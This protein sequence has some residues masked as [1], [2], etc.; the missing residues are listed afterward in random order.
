MQVSAINGITGFTGKT[1][2]KN[3]TVSSSNVAFE[4]EKHNNVS[5]RS[6]T[7]ATKAMMLAGLLSLG[8]AAVTSCDKLDFDDTHIYQIEIP[9]DT[10][11]EHHYYPVP[12][13]NTVDTVKIE[14]GYEAEPAPIIKDFFE[15]NGIDTG[16]G[17]IITRMM[18]LDEYRH[19]F[20]K[21]LFNDDKSSKKEMW[22]DV[23]TT[24]FDDD[25]GAYVPDK[26]ENYYQIG[27]STPDKDH[28]LVVKLLRLRNPELDK[29][30][31]LNYETVSKALYDT[32]TMT[33][34]TLDENGNATYDGQF[35]SGDVANS[36]MFIN[37]YGAKR[38]YSSIEIESE[39]PQDKIIE[40]Q[41]K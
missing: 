24:D 37:E 22:Y 12:G 28:Q 25:E 32:Q 2:L 1:Q 9:V 26:N 4:G 19:P 30:N 8:G 11:K 40:D 34:Y 18:Y 35:E 39:T 15:D 7:N 10:V 38:R 3:N 21:S 41:T 31:E 5:N 33:R 6:M 23:T 13:T 20:V 17:T 36:I 14:K 27:Y 29:N 16:D